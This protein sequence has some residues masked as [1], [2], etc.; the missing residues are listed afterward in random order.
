MALNPAKIWGGGSGVGGR[1]SEWVVC[2]SVV[3]Y[4]CVLVA[5]W[6]TDLIFPLARFA[7]FVALLETDH[8][9]I[10]YLDE[11]RIASVV[12]SVE[13]EEKS[14]FGC[15]RCKSCLRTRQGRAGQGGAG[16]T[17]GVWG[18]G[19]VDLLAGGRTD[20]TFRKWKGSRRMMWTEYLVVP[21]DGRTH[22][23]QDDIAA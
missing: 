16:R 8:C 9:C 7:V 11:V 1:G 17:D 12:D 22:E 23:E 14:F 13:L 6:M 19:D 5:W 20:G 10:L 15:G 2:G 21:W 18:G 4:E 3:R